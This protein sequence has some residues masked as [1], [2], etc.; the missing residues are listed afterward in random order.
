MGCKNTWQQIPLCAPKGMQK[1]IFQADLILSKNIK[2]LLYTSDKYLFQ[3]KYIFVRCL[4]HAASKS[5]ITPIAF[6]NF[7]ALKY[8]IHMYVCITS[9]EINHSN[10]LMDGLNANIIIIIN[11]LLIII[12]KN[13]P[14]SA[15][16]MPK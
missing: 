4:F 7:Y 8:F 6:Q 9:A 12:A 5:A 16:F 15:F 10:L 13:S 14:K 2:V 1:K 3:N 11:F